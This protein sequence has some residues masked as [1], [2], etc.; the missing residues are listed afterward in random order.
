MTFVLRSDP[1]RGRIWHQCG[2]Q[3][4]HCRVVR[5]GGDQGEGGEKKTDCFF[6]KR[7]FSFRELDFHPYSLNLKAHQ[8][9][10][11][12]VDQKSFVSLYTE[13]F[14]L[15][16]LSNLPILDWLLLLACTNLRITL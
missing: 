15:F 1:L 3:E 2:D 12:M 9:A 8:Y 13:D 5:A 6:C 14:T 11:K 10:P 16:L 4:R 7:C